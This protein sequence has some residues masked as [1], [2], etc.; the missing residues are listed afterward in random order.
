M[1]KIASMLH[2]LA[3]ELGLVCSENKYWRDQGKIRET[4]PV[5]SLYRYNHQSPMDDISPFPTERSSA[6]SGCHALTLHLPLQHCKFRL[7]SHQ[8]PLS[9]HASPGTVIAT[10]EE[11]LQVFYIVIWYCILGPM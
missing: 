8:G 2:E 9:F 5:L 4:E 10:I 3:E 11:Q 6:E 1:E 7:Q